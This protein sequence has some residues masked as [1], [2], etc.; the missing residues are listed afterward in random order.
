M[1]ERKH[2]IEE[3]LA[4][5]RGFL[6]STVE[7]M[8]SEDWSRVAHTDSAGWTVR[9]LVAHVVGAEPSMVAIIT[10]TQARGR[11]A[12]RPDFDL[13]FWNR[14]QVEKRAEKSPADLVAE[15]EQNRAAT[16]KLLAELPE[17]AL[18]LPVR[19]P[20][21]GDMTVEDVFRIIGFHER[22]HAE[23]IRRVIVLT[24]FTNLSGPTAPA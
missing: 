20:A 21:Y 24:G 3:W 4:S 14:R 15:M 11:Y 16:F 12:P 23:E 6:R 5:S 22:L 19:H 8:R 13:D 10:Q 9:D 7:A 18:D 17:S 1:L 2:H